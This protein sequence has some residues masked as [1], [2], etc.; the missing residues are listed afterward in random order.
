[1]IFVR[2]TLKK[3]KSFIVARY[4]LYFCICARHKNKFWNELYEYFTKSL[5]KSVAQ[6]VT[7]TTTINDTT[8]LT[9]NQK[10]QHTHR[11]TIDRCERLREANDVDV[12]VDDNNDNE[13]GDNNDNETT[14]AASAM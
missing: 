3:L 14:A 7:T 9:T 2:Y 5:N 10:K 6:R 4:F 13:G 8:T 11:Q 12:D 1:M